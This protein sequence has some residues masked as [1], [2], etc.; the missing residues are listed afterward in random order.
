MLFQLN[1]LFMTE[2]IIV[3]SNKQLTLWYFKRSLKYIRFKFSSLF[4]SSSPRLQ[5]FY[6]FERWMN[7]SVSW[8][9]SRTRNPTLFF[10]QYVIFYLH[11]FWVF[12]LSNFG[13]SITFC[14]L[15]DLQNLLIISEPN[16]DNPIITVY[17]YFFF[18]S[19]VILWQ[20]LSKKIFIVT[21]RNFSSVLLSIC[22]SIPL[23]EIIYYWLLLLLYS[24]FIVALKL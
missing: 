20:C 23:M 15:Y 21:F 22:I 5:F 11:F 13:I 12:I 16:V 24:L 2:K 19:T 10:L 4:T 7:L 3:R 14:V 18:A 8:K 1:H 17:N 6:Y 9:F